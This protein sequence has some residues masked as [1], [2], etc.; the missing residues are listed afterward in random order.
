[1]IETAMYVALGFLV[2]SVI[3]L[4]LSRPLWRRAVRLTTERLEATLPMSRADMEAD[5]DELR[6]QYAIKLRNFELALEK[7]KDKSTRY[8]V[9]R[10]KSRAV[11]QELQQAVND[12]K[13]E[14]TERH[15]Q[16]KVLESHLHHGGAPMADPAMDVPMARPRPAGQDSMADLTARADASRAD[17][18]GDAEPLRAENAR[19]KREVETM[20]NELA[21]ARD[22]S[23]RDWELLKAEVTELADKILEGEATPPRKKLAARMRKSLASS[24]VPKPKAAPPAGEAEPVLA[25]QPAAANGESKLR[26]R[27]GSLAQRL[28][29]LTESERK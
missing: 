21:A 12:L 14:L 4:L 9:D 27:L 3:A 18:S 15:N 19:L 13:S 11:A 7:E 26:S 24:E 2:A 8:L 17:S 28:E 20:R 29:S 25:Q 5:K 1:M 16:I 22:M 10:N 6:A 23:S